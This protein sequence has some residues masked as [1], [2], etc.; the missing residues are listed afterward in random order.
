M[1]RR[2]HSKSAP[3]LRSWDRPAIQILSTN[4]YS[5]VV[6]RREDTHSSSLVRI[7]ESL[8]AAVWRLAGLTLALTGALRQTALG[9]E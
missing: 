5:T 7:L 3:W 1:A 6:M 9:P 4:G 8:V 2:S